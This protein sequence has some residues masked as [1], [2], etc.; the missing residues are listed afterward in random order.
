MRWGWSLFTG[1]LGDLLRILPVSNGYPVNPFGSVSST[2]VCP[3]FQQIFSGP[4][5]DRLGQPPRPQLAVVRIV[6]GKC[7]KDEGKFIYEHSSGLTW[8]EECYCVKQLG[9][10]ELAGT[11]GG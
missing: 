4:P 3:P 5:I 10:P 7:V 11:D 9:G 1:L 8:C 2:S 6:C